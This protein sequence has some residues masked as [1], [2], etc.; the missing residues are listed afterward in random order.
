MTNTNA[1]FLKTLLAVDNDVRKTVEMKRFGLE[2]EVKALTPDE[3]NEIQQRST[4]L[5]ASK[6]KQTKVIDEDKF[7]YLTI[8]TA[9]IT[10]DWHEVAQAMN[11][12]DA[13]DAV[14]AKL[15]FGEVAYLLGEIAEL[16]GFDKDDEEQVE[17][18]KN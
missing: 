16:N 11:L 15:L 14:K 18:A 9:C 8:V 17:E 5:S 4:K 6:G 7:N 3:A 12:P 1:D 2:F 10:P 13:I